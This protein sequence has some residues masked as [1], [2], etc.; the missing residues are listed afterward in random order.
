LVSAPAIALGI[1]AIVVGATIAFALWSAGRIPREPAQFIVA[2]RSFGTLLLWVLLAGEVYTSFTFLGAAGW[3]YGRGAPA[4]YILAYGTCGY[5]FGYFL[6]PAIWRVAKERSLL[7]APDFF[8]DR[9]DSKALGI[10]IALLQF[11]FMIP[12]VTLQLTGLQILLGIAGYGNFNATAAVIAAFVL[13]A[14]FV[15]TAGL[16]GTAWASV[17]KD[18]L[19]LA[20]VIF[21]GIAIPLHFF[22]SIPAMFAHLR[23]SHAAMLT[24]KPDGAPNGAIWYVSTVL[25]TG[26]G[27]YMGPQSF[28]ATYSA[29]S[30]DALRRNAVFLPL[31]QV[32]LLLVFFAGFAALLVVP[33]L[34]GAR[35]DESFLL[36]VQRYY[37][38]W[39]MG[40]VAAAGSL[41][42]LVPAS[43]LLLAT[44]SVV[45]KNV[46][47]D[48]R[49]TR[50]LV[51]VVA[52]LALVLWLFEKQT[53]VGLLLIVYNGITQ[54]LP[55][56]VCAFIWRR[57][58][59]WGVGIGI[60]A[61]VA[62][63]SWLSTVAVPWGVNPGLIALAINAVVLVLL[64][65]RTRRAPKEIAIA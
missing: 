8:V 15:F 26:I 6:L 53:L 9:Y 42:A 56:V 22:G 55:G 65:L 37:P 18:V 29:K 41:A 39:V 33:G 14:L 34:H 40:L 36:V 5:V 38:P 30:D 62:A 19:V 16:R 57:A 13:I 35:V 24:L 32:V 44:A 48:A 23:A 64:S 60:A 50:P 1:V 51:L 10:A 49:F 7:T 17:I 59:A 2:G 63:A 31:Y 52:L 28:N 45:A 43:A 4:Y 3:A 25:L 47:G 58:T 46:L 11:V 54:F 61:G 12:Y 27:F 20:A 21:A